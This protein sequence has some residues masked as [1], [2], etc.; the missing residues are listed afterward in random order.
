MKKIFAILL[1][2]LVLIVPC[3]I[4]ASAAGA[5]NAEEQRILDFLDQYIQLGKTKYHI[6][7]EYIAQAKNHFLT[8]DITKTEADEI[9]DFIDEGIEILKHDATPDEEFHMEVLPVAHKEKILELGQKACEVVDL[10]L[11]YDST[12]TTV[13]ITKIDPA[14]GNPVEIFDDE[15]IVK[16]TGGEVNAIVISSA[17]LAVVMVAAFVISKKVKLF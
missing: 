9:I 7:D 14:T 16:T 17:I 8:A 13:V 10:T 5:I 6:P 4:G 12:E 15:P 1:A 3:C 11:T 2:L